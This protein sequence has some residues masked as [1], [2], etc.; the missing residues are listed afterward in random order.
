MKKGP[1]IKKKYAEDS[2]VPR[3]GLCGKTENLTRTE[4]CGQWICDDEDQ[5][6]MFS[7]ER[8]SCSRNHRRYTLC[9]YHFS[10]GHQGDWKTCKAC[11]E[12][13]EDDL[14]MYV[15]NGTN[16]YNFEVLENPPAF[17]PTHCI[18]CGK[19]IIKANGGYTQSSEGCVCFDCEESPLEMFRPGKIGLPDIEKR[20]PRYQIVETSQAPED[21][22]EEEAAY[23]SLK[24]DLRKRRKK[25]KKNR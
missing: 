2:E 18:R 10:E 4:C 1:K 25:A 3:C 6:V 15:D 20:R 23:E 7:Y 12:D 24:D 14:E 22:P 9:G 13:F 16:E 19:V 8:N 17:K 11:R 21:D 5:Y